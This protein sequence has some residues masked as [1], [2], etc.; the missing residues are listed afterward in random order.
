MEVVGWWCFISSA[1]K[2]Q[3]IYII[4]SR[5]GPSFFFFFPQSVLSGQIKARSIRRGASFSFPFLSFPPHIHSFFLFYPR[6]CLSAYQHDNWLLILVISRVRLTPIVSIRL[7]WAI[8]VTSDLSKGAQSPLSPVTAH[9]NGV[10]PSSAEPP[11][12][13]H[14][15]LHLLLGVEITHGRRCYAG[16]RGYVKIGRL[17]RN[18]WVGVVLARCTV[19]P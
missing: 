8:N 13:H 12:H 1:V 3:V 11:H 19:D 5:R 18:L 14:H 15:Y 7:P 10:K 4:K 16:Y 2:N 6:L 17:N 9:Q